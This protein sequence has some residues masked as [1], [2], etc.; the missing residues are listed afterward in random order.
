MVAPIRAKAPDQL[1]KY[2]EVH[3]CGLI[4]AREEALNSIDQSSKDWSYIDLCKVLDEAFIPSADLAEEDT[5]ESLIQDLNSA[6]GR[7]ESVVTTGAKKLK[8]T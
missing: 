4:W 6:N 2:R 7:T 3:Q 5:I 1:D 8:K